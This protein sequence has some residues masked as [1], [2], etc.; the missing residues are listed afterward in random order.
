MVVIMVF[1]LWVLMVILFDKSV[2]KE[3]E[4]VI[5]VLDFGISLVNDGFVI[6]LVIL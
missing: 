6:W 1:E 3:I 4:K 5:L 2:F